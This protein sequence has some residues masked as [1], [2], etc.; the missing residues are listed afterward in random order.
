[1]GLILS[2][3]AHAA[4]KDASAEPVEIVT[5]K[6]GD[7]QLEQDVVG[8]VDPLSTVRVRAQVSGQLVS[9]NFAEGRQ[10]QAGQIL[11]HIDP[12]TLQ[13]TVDQDGALIA[14]DQAAEEN[15]A[16]ILARSKPLLSKGL[17]SAEDIETKKSEIA[18]LSAK[19]R[20]DKALMKRDQVALGYTTITSPITGIAGIL[21]VTMGNVVSPQDPAGLVT[22]TQMQPID[23]LFPVA[24]G[25]LPALQRALQDAGKAGV[26]VE[27]WSQSDQQQLAKGTLTV[28]DNQ[29]DS[30][31]GTIR[32]K[33]R[34]PN[35]DMAL[36][37]GEFLNVHVV[38]A[39]RHDALIIPL[40]AVEREQKGVYV[41]TLLPDGR[42]HQTPIHIA[43]TVRGRVL[44]DQGLKEADRVVVNGQ[45]S[46]TEGVM[47]TVVAAGG[48]SQNG[49]PIQNSATDRVGIT[50]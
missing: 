44:V 42:A 5:L 23:V 22:V 8:H 33:A 4:V 9:V 1:L 28:V 40:D 11:A 32:L 6:P 21:N 34:F 17:V 35:A 13:A 15:A 41:W 7:F 39:T 25:T 36:W 2:K 29:V 43:Q 10:V 20:F 16:A 45:Y 30:T 50:P 26:E 46:L 14:Q 12:R 37:P 24:G 31:S 19:E 27:A 47:T 3:T 38:L 48:N 49:T 18:Q